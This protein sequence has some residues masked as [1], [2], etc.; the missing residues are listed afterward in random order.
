[1]RDVV[2]LEEDV[3][4]AGQDEPHDGEE[5]GGGEGRVEG[6]GGAVGAGEEGG[7]DGEEDGEQIGDAVFVGGVGGD[8]DAEGIIS[9][10]RGFHEN[11]CGVRG[12]HC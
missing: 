5:L 4:A 8:F 6:G 7:A 3:D 12:G 10:W 11:G 2:A 1:M 9:V